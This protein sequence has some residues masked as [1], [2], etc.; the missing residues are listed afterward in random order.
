MMTRAKL[1]NA[2]S[3]KVRAKF[4][5]TAGEKPSPSEKVRG[6]KGDRGARERMQ[7]YTMLKEGGRGGG[8]GG[9]KRETQ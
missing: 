4:R 5:E 9:E 6:D 3:V 8:N 2:R 7:M 1:G